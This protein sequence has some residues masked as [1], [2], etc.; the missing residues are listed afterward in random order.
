MSVNNWIASSLVS[1][2]TSLSLRNRMEFFHEP[3]ELLNLHR[4]QGLD[5]LWRDSL[6]CPTE[7]EYIQMVNNSSPF[8]CSCQRMTSL[9]R[10]VS[11]ETG[12]LFRIAIKLM[13]AKSASQ[14]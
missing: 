1:F 2:R 10:P 6:T 8:R 14:V 11:I 4:G 12:G 5:L 7:E 3:D 9:T 13:M